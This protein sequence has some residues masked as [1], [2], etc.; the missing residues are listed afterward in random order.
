MKDFEYSIFI[1]RFSP[2]HMAHYELL[3]IALQKAQTAI[4]I[5]A[6]CAPVS[7]ILGRERSAKQ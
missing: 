1:G 4:V 2:F 6:L 7:K 5:V 3:K